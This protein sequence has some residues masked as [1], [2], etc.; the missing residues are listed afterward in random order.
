MELTN[1]Y[2]SAKGAT[3]QFPVVPEEI[4]VRRE[5][6][7]DT[8]TILEIGEVELPIGEKIDEVQFS[9]FFPEEYDIFCSYTGIPSPLACDKQLQD[10]WLGEEPLRL[11]IPGL[12]LN[13]LVTIGT[14]NPTMKADDLYFDITL[15]GYKELTIIRQTASTGR[16][17]GSKPD[18]STY[19]VRP[20][21][22]LTSIAAG[23]TS[24][25]S[26]WPAIARRNGINNPENIAVGQRLVMK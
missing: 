20:G 19:A 21:D 10:W 4:A 25:I 23:I 11:I 13:C 15:R 22:T 26:N 2:L 17:A 16:P 9:S 6:L 7:F 14:Y 5:K 8:F 24:D 1:I 12:N 18:I 3:F